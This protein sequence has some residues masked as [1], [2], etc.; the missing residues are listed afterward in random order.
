[1]RGAGPQTAE[2][3]QCIESAVNVRRRMILADVRGGSR[4]R[5]ASAE[6]LH[7]SLAST[8]D[9]AGGLDGSLAGDEPV[10]GVRRGKQT[11]QDTAVGSDA[12]SM[13]EGGSSSSDEGDRWASRRGT[14][15]GSINDGSEDLSRATAAQIAARNL[16][17][18]AL[19]ANAAAQAAKEAAKARQSKLPTI[20]GMQRQGAELDADLLRSALR[21]SWAA[22]LNCSDPLVA[23]AEGVLHEEIKARQGVSDGLV[24]LTK[25]A[26]D[27]VEQR[28]ISSLQGLRDRLNSALQEARACN[29]PEEWLH[30][31]E[32]QRRR[33]HN[34]VEDLKGQNRVMCRVRPL[35]EKE[36]QR[37]ETE[38][39]SLVDDMTVEVP[40]GTFVFDGIFS[41]G[42]QAEVFNDCRDLVQSAVDGHNVTIFTYGHTG[43]GKTYT[44]LGDQSNPGIATRAINEIFALTEKLRLRNTVSISAT[45]VE[46]YNNHLTDLFRGRV[47]QKPSPRP[48]GKMM[49]SPRTVGAGAGTQHVEGLLELEASCPEDLHSMLTTGVAHRVTADNLQH[50]ESSRSHML[51]TIKVRIE[52]RQGIDEPVMAYVTLC[53]LGGC[54][55]LHADLAAEQRKEAIEINR[56]LSALLDVIEAICKHYKQIPFRNH[57]LTQLLQDSLGGTAKTLMLATL[58]PAA[59]A[60]HDTLMALKYAGRLKS[61]I[62]GAAIKSSAMTSTL[63]SKESP[64]PSPR[65][66]PRLTPRV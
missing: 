17:R 30:D 52:P 37:G 50:T 59:S 18:Q 3:R 43:T 55:R 12:S 14:S 15:S 13:S 29:V 56:S 34:M 62:A 8:D 57:K 49:T 26:A 66:T 10:G 9:L 51:F 11:S 16:L 1:M 39:I 42:T 23:Q 36:L 28:D 60:E 7:L 5:S 41:P 63:S 38:A 19:D 27:V 58:S 48:T 21:E 20:A 61:I 46:L 35:T 44:M 4:L 33:I 45:M 2:A 64:R 31:A 22:G 25:E 40:K 6:V 47:R 53:D 24:A 65:P 32:K 54:E